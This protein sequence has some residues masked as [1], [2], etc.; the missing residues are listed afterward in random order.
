MNRT[1]DYIAVWGVVG[2]ILSI[3]LIAYL[4]QVK[5]RK[6]IGEWTATSPIRFLSKAQQHLEDNKPY[7]C[8]E[9]LKRAIKILKSI[10]YYGDSMVN[11]YLEN[12]IGHLTGAIAAI[13]TP[14]FSKEDLNLTIF[15]ALNSVAYAE[16]KISE[17]NLKNG[18]HEQAIFLLRTTLLALTRSTRFARPMYLQKEHQLIADIE[19]TLIS[20]EHSPN[21]DESDFEKINTEFEKILE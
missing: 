17:Q 18:N 1:L 14:E 2:V 13:N 8:I 19:S 7:E 15:E 10:E 21:F 12:S 5:A 20:M 4:G 11:T 3:S 6:H 9:D 16:L